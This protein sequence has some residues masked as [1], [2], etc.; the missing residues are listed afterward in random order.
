MNT[1]ALINF[2]FLC[3]AACVILVPRPGIEP[4]PSAVKARR[5]NHWTTRE[6]PIA[7]LYGTLATCQ[8]PGEAL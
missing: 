1:H 4:V 7:I 2:F 6:F 8:V 5:P 3:C